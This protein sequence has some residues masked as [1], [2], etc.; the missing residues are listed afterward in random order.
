MSDSRTSKPSWSV[1][2]AH[3]GLALVVALLVLVL[4][5]ASSSEGPLWVDPGVVRFSPTQTRAFVEIH[6]RSGTV[7]PVAD[8]ELGGEDWDAL[9]FVDESFPR[10][11]PGVDSVVLELELSAAAFR[12][13]A[14]THR[15]GR[16]ELS[17]HSNQHEYVVPIEFVPSHEQSSGLGIGVFGV[18]ALAGLALALVA[19]H[20][21]TGASSRDRGTGG[22]DARVPT[23]LAWFGLL[24]V[25]ATLPVGLGLCSG[26][27]A[28]LVGPRELGQCRDGLGGAELLA[29]PTSLG[30]VWWILAL[31]VALAGLAALRERAPASAGLAGVRLLGFALLVVAL[32]CGLA[33][34]DPS[35]TTLVLAQAE[36]TRILG[37][38]LPRW[39]LLLQPVGFAL[40]LA[41]LTAGPVAEQT[42]PLDNLER[43]VWAGLVATT[44]LAGPTLPWISGASVPVLAHG[45]MILIELL[46]F[47][48]ELAGLAW[49]AARA[50]IWLRAR[51]LDDAKLAHLHARLTI[52]LALV[53]LAAVLAWRFS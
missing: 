37:L 24:V 32:A 8:F 45:A 46:T 7:R 52:P 2:S 22:P 53:H 11:I 28:A 40:A 44:Y 10:T 27:L 1:G 5:C 39:G 3:A 47:A 23:A 49:L 34:D 13:G 41:L 33:P 14:G 35:T 29:L 30:V 36:T 25:L 19:T 9:R 48:L 21:P 6:N 20:D 17:F 18:V 16:A 50:Q 4:G 51:G 38:T 15:S 43:I 12:D 31:G 42:T 26:R